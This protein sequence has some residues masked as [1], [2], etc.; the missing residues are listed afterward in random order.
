[1]RSA[2]SG[3]MA[4]ELLPLPRQTWVPSAVSTATYSFGPFPPPTII[5]IVG[6]L[7]T[8]SGETTWPV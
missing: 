2:V 3:R 7:S 8:K 4:S 1:M 5:W 6:R